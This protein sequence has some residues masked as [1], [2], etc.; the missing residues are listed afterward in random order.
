MTNKINV[1]V[2][3]STINPVQINKTI[4]LPSVDVSFGNKILRIFSDCGADA[5]RI[6]LFLLLKIQYNK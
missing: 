3:T 1:G 2:L 6:L 4:E 5:S